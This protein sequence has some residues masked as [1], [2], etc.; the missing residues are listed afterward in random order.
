MKK[1]IVVFLLVLAV[2]GKAQEL[3]DEIKRLQCSNWPTIVDIPV[4]DNI[5][6]P[7]LTISIRNNFMKQLLLTL[8][9]KQVEVPFSNDSTDKMSNHYFL[10]KNIL[11]LEFGEKNVINIAISGDIWF[12]TKVIST[13]ITLNKLDLVIVPLIVQKDGKFFIQFNCQVKFLDLKDVAPII[14]KCIANYVNTKGI[15]K[16]APVDISNFI[17][18][19][20][21][22]PFD[23]TNNIAPKVINANLLS[24]KDYYYIKIDIQ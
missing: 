19:E 8:I 4:V 20:I 9:G 12:R 21:K 1:I 13:K 6:S 3:P 7:D 23:G 2:Q 14:E 15:M 16:I 18:A 11:A 24:D 22:N 5:S 10:L 17:A